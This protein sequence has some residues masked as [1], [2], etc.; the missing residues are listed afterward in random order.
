M[1]LE[2]QKIIAILTKKLAIVQGKGQSNSQ[3]S[4]KTPSTDLIQK[5]GGQPGQLG[6]TRMGYGSKYWCSIAQHTSM[7]NF[8]A[9]SCIIEMLSRRFPLIDSLSQNILC[10][11]QINRS[12]NF[13]VSFLSLNDLYRQ[14]TLLKKSGIICNFPA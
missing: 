6:K 2:L 8:L 12:S 10:Y 4:S 9:S 1:L 14:L 11:G 3:A 7:A 13:E 5:S